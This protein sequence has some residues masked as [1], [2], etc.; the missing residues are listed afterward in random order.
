MYTHIYIVNV[1]SFRLKQIKKS[2]IENEQ[3]RKY[4]GA[5]DQP[6]TGTRQPPTPPTEPST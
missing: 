3:R 5:A 2:M 1:R 4:R 6:L